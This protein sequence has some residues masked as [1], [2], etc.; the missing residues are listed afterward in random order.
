MF[1]NKKSVSVYYQFIKISLIPT[2]DEHLIEL[3]IFL[4]SK[5]HVILLSFT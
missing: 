3:S 2:Y 1:T 4:I 5:I